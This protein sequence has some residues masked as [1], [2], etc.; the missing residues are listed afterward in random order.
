MSRMTTRFALA[1]SLGLLACSDSP[2]DVTPP[3][4][5]DTR[6]D[7]VRVWAEPWSPV[8]SPTRVW[9]YHWEGGAA[10]R[11][12]V[13]RITEPSM[14]LWEVVDSSGIGM[15][16]GGNSGSRGD[17]PGG[18]LKHREVPV[19]AVVT[20]EATFGESWTS[21]PLPHRFLVSVELMDGRD[22]AGDFVVHIPCW[23]T[24][25]TLAVPPC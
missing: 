9:V 21:A 5:P 14:V 3:P 20:V 8:G 10:R 24:P 1:A 18:F 15:C 17:C 16:P 19:G 2:T 13:T 23:V 12:T 4:D 22:G 25:S 7:E 11:V 6:P